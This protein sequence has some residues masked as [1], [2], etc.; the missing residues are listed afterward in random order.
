MWRILFDAPWPDEADTLQRPASI[1]AAQ[2]IRAYWRTRGWQLV[3]GEVVLWVAVVAWE[4]P[5]APAYGFLAGVIALA[6]VLGLLPPRLTMA[7]L[8]GIVLLFM[9]QGMLIAGL[10][11]VTALSYMVPYTI[12][13]MV[14]SGR[15][16]LIAQAWCVV[17]F[18]VS[19]VY[20]VLPTFPQLDPPRYILVSYNILIAAFTFQ[21]LRLL[22]QL[23]VELNAETVTAEVRQQSHQFLAR[24][25]HELRTPLN[26][27][28]GFAKLLRRTDLTDKQAGFLVHVVDE[29]EHLNRLVSDLLDSA[30]L[31]TGK[32]TLK[33]APCDLNAI[34]TTV[35]DEH[36]PHVPPTVTLALDLTPEL[37][38]LDCDRMRVR[39]ALGNLVSN[40][41]KHTRTGTITIRT[42][43]RG[44]AL[45]ASVTDTGPGIPEEQQK[46]I[47]VP[48]VQLDGPGTE[49]RAG[50]GLGLDIAL[51]LARLHG[52]NIHLESLPGQGSTFTLEL[53]LP[54]G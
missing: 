17:V 38:P 54:G 25:S 50:V 6:V 12:A 20:E 9:V 22:N 48:F 35:A 4:V 27:V 28:L 53:P 14:L 33:R 5:H 2:R 39:Q 32:L 49:R 7:G 29:G 21:T 52:G 23:A 13:G 44:A 41:I 3:L 16:R 42:R 30:H 1:Q 45:L 40:A 37:P 36:R 43:Q 19:L 47:F 8:V 15:R 24:V 46:L 34:C 18:W 31:S 26:S 51:Q 11:A 10:G